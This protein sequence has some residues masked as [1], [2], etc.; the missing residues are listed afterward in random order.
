MAAR[1]NL[2]VVVARRDRCRDGRLFCA[3]SLLLCVPTFHLVEAFMWSMLASE[4]DVEKAK[5]SLS[6]IAAQMTPAQIAEGDARVAAFKASP[7]K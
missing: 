2:G 4:K 6:R 5:V 3:G 7:T 1:P